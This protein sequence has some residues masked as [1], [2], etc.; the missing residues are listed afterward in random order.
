MEIA[1][2]LNVTVPLSDI[3]FESVVLAVLVAI[4]G[5]VVVKVLTAAFTQ[6][7]SR[8]SKLPDLVVEFLVRFFAILLYVLLTLIVIATIG[9]DISSVVIGLS[10]VIGL[11]LGFGL[12]DTVTNLAAGI[13]LAAFRPIDKDELVE[14]N[15]IS[16]TVVSVGI[17]ATELVRADNTYIT[18]PNSLVWGSPVINSTRMETRRVEVKVRVPYDSDLDVAF[19][20]AT[21]LMTAHEGVLPSPKPAV[22]VTELADS[23]VNLALRAW[24]KTPDMWDVQWDLNRDVVRAFREAGIAIPFPKVDVHLERIH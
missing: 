15:G 23:S 14:V 4:I 2:I 7:L 3:T 13:W 8:V 19:R 16:G 11:I 20:V 24:A 21:E 12:Q 17:M 6:M 18:I 1:E 5:W 9:F 10:A 22:V